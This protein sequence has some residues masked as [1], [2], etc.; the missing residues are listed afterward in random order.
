M[1]VGFVIFLLIGLATGGWGPAAVVGLIVGVVVFMFQED[2]AD[3]K[4]YYNRM[5]YLAYGKEP[6]WKYRKR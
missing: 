5:D 4:A 1:G 3:M 6:D 2:K